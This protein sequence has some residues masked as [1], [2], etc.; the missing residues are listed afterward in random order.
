MLLKD[1]YAWIT[2]EVRTMNKENIAIIFL[3]SLVLVLIIYLAL[4]YSNL[5][6]PQTSAEESLAELSWARTVLVVMNLENAENTNHSTKIMNCGVELSS[7]LAYSD[8]AVNSIVIEKGTCYYQQNDR[9]VNT[10]SAEC[11]KP[12]RFNEQFTINV[13]GS[14]TEESRYYLKRIDLLIPLNYSGQCTLRNM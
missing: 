13:I 6:D 11:L 9:V 14:N 4:N 2:R 12:G 10:S 3:I 5:S 7:S 8:R 1:K